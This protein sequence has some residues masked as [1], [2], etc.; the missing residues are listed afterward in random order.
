M[1]QV[2]YQTE[3]LCEYIGGVLSK[4]KPDRVIWLGYSPGFQCVYKCLINYNINNV[5]VF[6]N[7]PDK[8]GWDLRTKIRGN[9][10]GLIVEPFQEV[11]DVEKTIFFTAST[12]YK[13]FVTQLSAFGVNEERI[14]DLNDILEKWM[15]DAERKT[16]SHFNLLEGRELQ[17]EQLKILKMFKKFCMEKNL[18]WYLGEGTLLGAVRHKGFIPWDDDIDVFMPY[19]D[20][21]S[22]ISL[23]RND[24]YFLI[25]WRKETKYPFQFAKVIEKNTY[26]IHTIP[27]GYFTLGCYMDIFPIA[28]YPCD[29]AAVIKK[30]HRH[31]ELDAKWD[32]SLILRD[33]Y[34]EVY[35]DCRQQITDEKYCIPFDEAERVGTMQQIAGN[36]WAIN[37]DAFSESIDMQ[38]EDDVFPVPIGFDEF[39][40][41]R[42]GDYMT[43][44]PKDKRR[45][46]SYPTYRM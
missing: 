17:L 22:C 15:W 10:K 35:S 6:D 2:H 14:I 5:R 3:R 46:H 43:L 11:N 39:L 8:Q 13:D 19:E 34:R 12:H 20:Y 16:V 9:E 44:P 42:Y 24:E 23:F 25:D 45:V 27:F 18:R 38:F 36:P 4:L 7:D 31:K 30:Y 21:L 26:Q 29:E 33:R 28:G 37:R 1:I 40:T 41:A 32:S